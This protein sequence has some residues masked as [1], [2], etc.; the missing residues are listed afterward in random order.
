MGSTVATVFLAIE[1]AHL[2]DNPYCSGPSS[3]HC[4]PPY[5]PTTRNATASTSDWTN[6]SAASMAHDPIV[7]IPTNPCC[8]LRLP[9]VA[10]ACYR[11]QFLARWKG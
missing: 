8:S 1:P 11:F 5:G 4:S 3:P 2:P 7:S 9:Q 10:K 6:C